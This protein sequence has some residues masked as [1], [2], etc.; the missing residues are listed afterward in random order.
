MDIVDAQVHLGPGG[1]NETLAAMDAL[2]IRSALI[3]EFWVGAGLKNMPAH[4]VGNLRRRV[5]P[6]S[7]LA[8]L[9][10][11][12]R[13][14]YLRWILD[15]EDPELRAMIRLMRD[16][17]HGLALRITPG[18]NKADF[19]ALTS[20]GFDAMFSAAAEC[21]LP[22]FITI[23]GNAPALRPAITKFR[24][25]MFIIDHC[26]M[27]FTAAMIQRVNLA[28]RIPSMGGSSTD[29]E[30]EKVLR[31][32]DLPNVALKWAHAQGL[33]EVPAY[34]YADL[35][36]FLRRALDAFGAERVMWAADAA[37]ITRWSGDSWGQ[38]LFWLMDNPDLTAGER[39]M[40][41]GGTAR[42][43]LKW[44]ASLG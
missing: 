18:L 26:G 4:T 14:A 29:K 12:E 27:P 38:L 20:G 3:D 16:A 10:H 40:I 2:G 25:L 19:A 15:R 7:E 44:P 8:A 39:E 35:R 33:F 43:I 23:P 11:P 21:G 28:E 6:T 31:L 22:I 41:L 24:D 9:T 13:F 1:I 34:P 30:F 42:R 37:I 5:T 17:P 32:A 36:P